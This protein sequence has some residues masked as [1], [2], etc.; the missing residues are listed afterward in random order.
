MNGSAAG[1]HSFRTREN[2]DRL[3]GFIR[4]FHLSRH[5]F[6]ARYE[7]DNLGIYDY[8]TELLKSGGVHELSFMDHTPGQGQYRDLEIYAASGAGPRAATP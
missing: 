6:H 7:I 1:K 8:L 4:E 5:R 3:A 2:L